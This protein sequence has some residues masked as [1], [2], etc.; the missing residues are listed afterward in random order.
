[1]TACCWHDLGCQNV[2]ADACTHPEPAWGQ[3]AGWSP[4]L[5]GSKC[6]G[7]CG[8]RMEKPQ[9]PLKSSNKAV[10]TWNDQKRMWGSFEEPVL[11]PAVQCPGLSGSK[12]GGAADLEAKVAQVDSDL[13]GCRRG[14]H[15]A[16]QVGETGVG[17]HRVQ[18]LVAQAS[19]P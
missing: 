3:V 2:M 4:S 14:L 11:Q 13:V 17:L 7:P 10:S 6:S 5:L 12:T 9:A 16:V 19:E 15:G 8:C 1:M 18:S